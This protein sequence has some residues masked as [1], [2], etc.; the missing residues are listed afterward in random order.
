MW[1]FSQP[2]QFLPCSYTALEES[3]RLKHEQEFGF[4]NWGCCMLGSHPRMSEL[5][6]VWLI[7]S[8]TTTGGKLQTI[9]R[10]LQEVVMTTPSLLQKKTHDEGQTCI[11]LAMYCLT[12]SYV[13][14]V[15]DKSLFMTI[16]NTNGALCNRKKHRSCTFSALNIVYWSFLSVCLNNLQN[17]VE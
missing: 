17:R 9:P 15:L 11:F 4:P 10:H 8:T 3:S 6:L 13:H 12:L 2:V 7:V 14:P 5:H 1:S 16:F